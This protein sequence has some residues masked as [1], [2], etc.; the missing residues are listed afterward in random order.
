MPIRP[1]DY[2]S[3]AVKAALMR[4]VLIII[5]MITILA[6][7]FVYLHWPALYNSV[8]NYRYARTAKAAA[9]YR[10]APEL[11]VY[12]D[13]MKAG[14]QLMAADKN[15]QREGAW[16]GVF[17]TPSFLSQPNGFPRQPRCMGV[18]FLHALPRPSGPLT[19]VLVDI[20]RRITEDAM[21]VMLVPHVYRPLPT[22]SGDAEFPWEELPWQQIPG[23]QML[24][25]H[26]SENDRTR[27]FAG[28]LDPQVPNHFTFDC[29]V[30]ADRTTCDGT[31]GAS[32]QL[33]LAA[34]PGGNIRFSTVPLKPDDSP[35][36]NKIFLPGVRMP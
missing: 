3:L 6:T 1:P 14:R 24:V 29:M 8:L 23:D 34:R 20:Q 12:D 35:G 13:D 10:A 28:Q 32:G 18:V 15:Y 11:V 36:G 5:V 21:L 27:I 2:K 19:L 26:A 22:T 9:A 25:I 7:L 17:H 16:R 33:T 30:N 4:R 31:L